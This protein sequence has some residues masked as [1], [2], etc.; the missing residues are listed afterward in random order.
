MRAADARPF[1]IFTSLR[2][3][4]FVSYHRH[5]LQGLESLFNFLFGLKRE[6]WTPKTD[7]VSRSTAHSPAFLQLQFH[8]ISRRSNGSEST[9]IS[10]RPYWVYQFTAPQKRRILLSGLKLKNEIHRFLPTQL[11]ISSSYYRTRSR[12]KSDASIMKGQLVGEAGMLMQDQTCHKSS[13]NNKQK[14]R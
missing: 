2:S 1:R 11:Q 6:L 7:S 12:R 3:C 5:S 9:S 13:R 10:M 4:T 14:F 8:R